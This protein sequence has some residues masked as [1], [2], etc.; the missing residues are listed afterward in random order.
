MAARVSYHKYMGTTGKEK[1]ITIKIMRQSRDTPGLSVLGE[2]SHP[3]LGQATASLP[4]GVDLMVYEMMIIMLT[5][6]TGRKR[7]YVGGVKA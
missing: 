2:A 5:L 3:N 7:T 4:S 1:F 6:L